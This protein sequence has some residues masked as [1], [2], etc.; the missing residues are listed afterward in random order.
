MVEGGYKVDLSPRALRDL[1]EIVTFIAADNASA[2][3]RFGQRLIDK[4]RRSVRIHSQAACCRNLL[5]RPFASVF[6]ARTALFIASI[7]SKRLLSCHA[8]G[9]PREIRPGFQLCNRRATY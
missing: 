9:M 8:S 1:E 4:Q 6:F 5:I 7:T 2:A 3:E